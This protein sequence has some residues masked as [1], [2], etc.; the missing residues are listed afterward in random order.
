MAKLKAHGEEIARYVSPKWGGLISIRSDGTVLRRTPWSGWKVHAR[1]KPGVDLEE[2][3]EKK[4]EWFRGIPENHWMRCTTLPSLQTLEEWA[5]AGIAETPT[6]YE[7]E[8]DGRG[9]D[10]SPSWLLILG[11]L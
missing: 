1:V 7:V 4:R 3:V 11:M 5:E 10:G 6:G 9:P 8:P 2:W